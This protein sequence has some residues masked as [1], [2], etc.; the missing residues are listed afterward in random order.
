MRVLCS[1]FILL[2][3]VTGCAM[4][5]ELDQ[6]V[7]EVASSK[8]TCETNPE[9][10]DGSLE[11]AS[12]FAVRGTVRKGYQLLEGAGRRLAY[13]QR[14]YMTQ[15]EGNRRT[16]AVI[17]LDTPTYVSYVEV[18]PAS[19]IPKLALMTTTDEPPRFDVSFDAVHDK[20]H[21]DVEGIQPV[22]F[23]IEREVRYLRLSADGIEDRQNS[24]RSENARIEIPL[25]GASIREVKFYVRQTP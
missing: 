8:L 6:P 25:K 18:Y 13:A 4:L 20:Q 11:T 12:T 9:L 23:H 21:R 2:I 7:V 3:G 10:V 22:R 24:V 17:K 1:L 14:R 5:N 19:R 15:V 16:E